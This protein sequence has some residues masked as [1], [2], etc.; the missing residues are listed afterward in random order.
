VSVVGRTHPKWGERAMAFVILRQEH[1]SKWKGNS[2]GFA[3]ELIRHARARLPGFAC[4]E[5]VQILDELPVSH[6]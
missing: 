1:A 4:P 6:A 2:G 5:W 3:A